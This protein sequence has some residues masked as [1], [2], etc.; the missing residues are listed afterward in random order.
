MGDSSFQ[1]KLSALLME[2]FDQIIKEKRAEYQLNP[3]KIPSKDSI[4]AIINNYTTSNA[5]VSM[6]LNL[7]PGPWGLIA[8]I[9]ELGVIL[10]NQCHLIYD[11]G[12]AYG[13]PEVLTKEL[14]AG[15]LLDA[16][17]AGGGAL[18]AIH[19]NKVILKRA[20]LRFFQKIVAVLGG[21]IT[22]KALKSALSKCV[23][24]LGAAAI[25]IWVG[26]T[27]KRVGKSAIEILSKE[28]SV[29]KTESDEDFVTEISK[30]STEMHDD[31]EMKEVVERLRLLT[32][33][34]AIDGEAHKQE[35]L[36]I[37]EIMTNYSIPNDDKSQ[38]VDYLEKCQQCEVD[39]KLLA[40]NRDEALAVLVDMIALSS[41]DGVV[42]PKE[43]VFI[44]K[45]GEKLGIKEDE[46]ED[47]F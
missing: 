26:Y 6:S 17:G 15:V 38:I 47:L 22:Q 18:L 46:I 45:T 23:P 4:S 5:T 41:R 32:C 24:F 21:K 28:I 35:S 43:A 29:E 14:L 8:I 9:P 30:K 44:R 39:Y 2:L 11:I 7:V 31:K 36:Y 27:T 12:M 40:S 13:K 16:F 33:L 10:R 34:A 25:S 3:E 19:G 20:S 37:Q 1:E 42:K